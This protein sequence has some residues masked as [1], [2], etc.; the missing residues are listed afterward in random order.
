MARFQKSPFLNI[1][2][3]WEDYAGLLLGIVV[4]LSPWMAGQTDHNAA[5][6][7]ATLTGLLL[8]IV[9]GLEIMWLYRWHELATFLMGA[10]LFLSPFVLEYSKMSPLAP[11]H[12]G[13]GS[14]IAILALLEI[15]QDWG[16]TDDD[17]ASH[18][19]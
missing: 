4:L 7:S 16:L 5:V 18:G 14:V 17:L 12:I 8:V 6:T 9:A 10:W 3:S 15:W 11:L 13:L 2:R 1:H 19:R